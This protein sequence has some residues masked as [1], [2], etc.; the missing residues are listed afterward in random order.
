MHERWREKVCVA[1]MHMYVRVCVCV[2]L[3]A[4]VRM[5][6]CVFVDEDVITR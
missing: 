2:Y 5:C 3:C 6:V 1:C 4:Y